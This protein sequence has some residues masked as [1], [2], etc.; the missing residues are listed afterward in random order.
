M[1]KVCAVDKQ[2]KYATASDNGLLRS[3]R[4]GCGASAKVG[5]KRKVGCKRK[6]VRSDRNGCR[7]RCGQNAKTSVRVSRKKQLDALYQGNAKGRA[8][9]RPDAI[10]F[11]YPLYKR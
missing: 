8:E 1:Q 3:L 6:R 4:K 7:I 5:Y 2:Q 10:N 11:I 9:T